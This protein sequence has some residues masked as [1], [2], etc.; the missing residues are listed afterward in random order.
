MTAPSTMVKRRLTVNFQRSVS[1]GQ[2]Q[3]MEVVVV[4]L[5]DPSSPTGDA[6]LVGGTQAQEVLLTNENNPVYFDLVPTDSPGLTD[7]LTYRI[8]WREKYMGQQFTQD[9]V[10]PDFDCDYDDLQDLGNVIGGE[11]YIQWTDRLRPGGVAGL[12]QQGQVIDSLGIVVSG[13][14]AAAGVQGNL[15]AEIVARQQADQLIISQLTDS[16][17][18]LI[19]NVYNVTGANL[20]AEANARGNAD[21]IEKTA[22]QNADTNEQSLRQNADTMLHTLISTNASAIDSIVN[23]ELPAKADLVNGQIP[24][25]QIPS[26]AFNE[27]VPVASQAAML[28]LTPA[29]ISPGDIAVRPDG[30][31]ILNAYPASTLSNWIELSVAGNVS[32]VNGQIGAV[33]LGAADVGARPSSQPLA[34]TDITGL[35]PALNA[36]T[37]T[38]T[39]TALQNQVTG[40]LND[41]TI[42]RTGTGNVIPHGVQGT[43]VAFLNA[44]SQIVNKAGQ[45]INIGSGAL[46][47]TD[48]TGLQP[49]LNAKLN[50]NDPTV[51]NARTPTSHAATHKTGGSDPVTPFPITDVTGLQAIVT[52]NN[53]TSTSNHGNRI[54]ALES[55]VAAGGGTGGGGGTSTKDVWWDA[56][57]ATTDFSTVNIKSP[58]GKAL[59]DSHLYYDPTGAAEG[60]AV[61]PYITPNGHL[62]LRQ[63]NEANPADPATATQANLDIT[64]ATV[65]TKADQA[66]LNSTNA[67][68]AL[69]ANQSDLDSTNAT[70]ALKASI[71]QLNAL[72][73]T[74]ATKANQSALDTT[75]NTVGTKADQSD[76][77][78]L[79]TQ[80]GTLATSASVSA[81]QTTVGTKADATAL[82]STNATVATKA[83]QSDLVALQNTVSTKADASALATTNN[84]VATLQNAMPAKA[85]LV[86]GVIPT[87][88]LPALAY[89]STYVVNNKA[90]M[91]GLTTAQAQ[92]GDVCVITATSDAGSYILSGTDPSVAANWVTLSTPGGGGSVT[93]VNGQLGPTV[94]LAASDVG[95]RSSS[96]LINQSE[97]NG[98]PAALTSKANQSDLTAGLAGKTAPTDV[99]G[100]VSQASQNKLQAALVATAAIATLSGQ[101]SLDGVLAPLGAIV[102]LTAQ[103][104]SAANGLY[105]V[106]SGP[107]T[108]STD[109][110]AGDYFVRGS[111]VT[112]SGGANNANTFWQQTNTSGIVAT[113]NNNW[114]KIMSAGAP[115]N[116]TASLGV[117]K[118]GSDFRAQVVSGGGILAVAGG[119]QLDPQVSARKF[120]GDVPAGATVATI[121]H[122]LNTT[123]VSASFRDKAAGDAILLGWKPT[124]ANTI[125]A[126]FDSTPAAGQ[127]RVVVIG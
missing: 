67:A 45:V 90:A 32:S 125:S 21:L 1:G 108:R 37:D 74:V 34:I 119:L 4:P 29:Q 68:V 40:I 6:T 98:L 122:N 127:W 38:T 7:R 8:A 86:G 116:F 64:N 41:T 65:A 93:S 12:N 73:D 105:A 20:A 69:K 81:L 126:E 49:A 76:L 104:S 63:R 57:S 96:V 18:Q 42:V 31:W 10:M 30:T 11:T 103:S 109:M 106:A 82:T 23:T 78:A 60:E 79:Q 33:T 107:W 85:D 62:Q 80:V 22:R 110:N 99:Q 48:V 27:A 13:A 115:P 47:I 92:P 39:T 19:T 2:P 95:A 117:Q 111:I 53:L 113:N 55:A 52:N 123:D 77:T 46:A 58:F 84:N 59:A 102:L 50:A 97:V 3:M 88:Q 5:T 36:K 70:V 75:N 87:N 28:A 61:F 71:V 56:P 100:I 83:A 120:A 43:D 91:L 35:Q 94:V 9:F 25:S 54:N 124:G 72:G 17:G 26:S 24:S 118:V 15:D 14:E 121:T 89:T 101:Q 44:N 112:V 66:S 16:T 114:S 51:T